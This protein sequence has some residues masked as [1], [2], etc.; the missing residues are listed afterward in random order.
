MAETALRRRVVGDSNSL[1]SG[2]GVSIGR[3]SRLGAS[4]E[5][6]SGLGA[7]VE[8]SSGLGAFVG[9]SS[10]LGA[11]VGLSSGGGVSL[12]SGLGISLGSGLG[13]ARVAAVLSRLSDSLGVDLSVGVAFGFGA[14]AGPPSGLDGG[15]GVAHQV[16]EDV[17]D[18]G[19]SLVR[20][21]RQQWGHLRID[22][23]VE[24]RGVR[25]RSQRSCTFCEEPAC[26]FGDSL[27]GH[28]LTHAH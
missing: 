3:S 10:G 6:S 21:G 26:V 18:G 7:S 24:S 25:P 23:R 15:P 1:G 9:L 11:C 20:D 17:F 12:G 14:C 13:D 19:G 16:S 8:L 27:L 4:V 28:S 22:R 5:L 2:L